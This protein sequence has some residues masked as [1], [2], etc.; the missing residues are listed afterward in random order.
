MNASKEYKECGK[1]YELDE[2]NINHIAQAY[3]ERKEFQREKSACAVIEPERVRQE[4]YNLSP[5]SYVSLL[6]PEENINIIELENEMLEGKIRIM[7]LMREEVSS[8]PS[9]IFSPALQAYMRLFA[10]HMEEALTSVM[11][12]GLKYLKDPELK[13]DNA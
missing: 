3:A 10:L 5:S 8:M 1:Q 11:L 4:G 7:K 9:R 12:N 6:E 13:E 2:N